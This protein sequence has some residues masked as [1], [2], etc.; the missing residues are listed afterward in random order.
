MSV[1]TAENLVADKKDWR[2][3]VVKH[4]DLFRTDHCGYWL[5]GVEHGLQGWLAWEDDGEHPHGNEPGREE[6]LAAWACGAPLPPGWFRLDESLA[7]KAWDVGVRQEGETWY[8]EGD[9]DTYDT[10][11]Q[12]A[13]LGELRYG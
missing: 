10:V 13:L 9:S 11:M 1:L 3:L 5:R 6:A 4:N 7:D 8:E 2:E 12:F